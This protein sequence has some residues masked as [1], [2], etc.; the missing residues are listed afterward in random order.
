MIRMS[1]V[2]V[3]LPEITIEPSIAPIVVLEERTGSRWFP[4]FIGPFEAAAIERALAGERPP[5]P[6]THDLLINSIR[7]LG[8][9]IEDVR[10]PRLEDG[11]FFALLRVRVPDGQIREI[12][13]RPS[14]AMAVAARAK[15]PILVDPEVLSEAQES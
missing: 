9:T 3:I 11:T 6:M 13:C 7:K 14:D 8:G 10:I 2:R 4:I 12:D 5:R 1:I 15:C